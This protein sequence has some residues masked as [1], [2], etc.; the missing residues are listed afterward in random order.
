MLDPGKL[1][2]QRY[3]IREVLSSGLLSNVYRADD[4][5]I[6]RPVVLKEV[7]GSN[8]RAMAARV[9][10]ETALY[11]RLNHPNIVQLLDVISVEGSLFLVFPWIEGPTLAQELLRGPLPIEAALKYARD[12]AGALAVVHAHQIVHRDLKPG[13]ILLSDGRAVLVDFGIA[14][15]VTEDEGLAL[16]RSG[17]TLGTP[18]YMAPE[19]LQNDPVGAPADIYALGTLLFE[20]LA[21]R[22]PFSGRNF[23]EL[24]ANRLKANPPPLIE[25]R[26]DV[27]AAVSVLVQQMMSAT[28]ANRPSAAQTFEALNGITALPVAGARENVPPPVAAGLAQTLQ[29]EP[30]VEHKHR[31]SAAMPAPPPPVPAMPAPPGPWPTLSVPVAR[32]PAPPPPPAQSM[33]PELSRTVAVRDSAVALTVEERTNVELR[34]F[35]NDEVARQDELKRSRD[36]Y[37]TQLSAD[38]ENLMFQAKI[39]FALWVLFSLVGF[40]VFVFGIALLYMGKWQ[41]GGATLVSESIVIFIQKLFKDREDEFR[42]RAAKKNRHVELGNLWNL[43]AQSLDGLD[44]ATRREKLGRLT[45]AIIEQVGH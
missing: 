19:A 1:L 29:P 37:R 31:D 16:T 2:N 11:S 25:F 10:R 12:I 44:A 35:F 45:D 6:Q 3:A 22:P 20:S 18:L 4:T 23:A 7:L 28:P 30:E 36:F 17:Q 40:V 27:P 32:Q 38:Y 9:Q 15:E 24:V 34:G 26:A 42:E 13:N 41:E 43:A 8:Q 39:S 5:V 21:G 33:D 14:K